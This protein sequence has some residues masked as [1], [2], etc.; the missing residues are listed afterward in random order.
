MADASF[1]HQSNYPN[2]T[3]NDIDTINAHYP[4]MT[5][6]AKHNPYFPSLS[7]AYGESTFTCPGL[8]ISTSFAQ[9]F[10]PL[11]VWNYHFNVVDATNTDNGLGVPHTFEIPAIFGP[12]STSSSQSSFSTY[13]AA[14]VPIVMNYWISF[15]RDLDPNPRRA[16]QAPYW[17]PFLNVKQRLLLEINSTRIELVPQDQLNRCAF[18]KTLA[19]TMEQ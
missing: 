15:V 11:Q 4:L 19:I 10:N 9:Y 1:F 8:Q 13:N 12:D 6:V 2:L 14:I 7:E 5:P 16:P 18:W 17:E 3:T